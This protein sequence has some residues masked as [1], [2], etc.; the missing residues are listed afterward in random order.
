[1]TRLPPLPPSPR[2]VPSPWEPRS[3][4]HLVPWTLPP[5]LPPTL[6]PT[7]TGSLA[8]RGRR[9]NALPPFSPPPR[10]L[11]RFRPKSGDSRPSSPHPVPP[12]CSCRTE[13]WITCSVHL[14]WDSSPL[15]ALPH[16][17][18]SP[19]IPFSCAHGLSPS[20]RNAVSDC[21]S[22]EI[23]PASIPFKRHV[24]HLCSV[25]FSAFASAPYPLHHSASSEG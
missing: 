5:L 8:P 22:C 4:P 20:M 18:S 12:V 6:P 19:S 2:L 1:M 3:P 14:T 25:H 11:V 16:A 24:V 23:D 13:G 9:P 17:L 10:P 21:S 15:Q 7:P